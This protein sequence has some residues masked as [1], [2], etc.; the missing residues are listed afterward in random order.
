MDPQPPEPG[1]PPATGEVQAVL[2]P[3]VPAVVAVMVTHDPG[4]WFEE[5]L[6]SLAAQTYPD[7]SLLVVDTA[8]LEDPT[9]RVHAVVPSAHVHRSPLA[10]DIM[11]TKSRYFST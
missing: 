3:V 4:P 9:E 1:A 6:A 7:L 2:P 10:K 8:S 11:V 5:T